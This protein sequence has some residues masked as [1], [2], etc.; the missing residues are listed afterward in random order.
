MQRS[1]SKLPVRLRLAKSELSNITA[2]L[3]QV[4]RLSFRLTHR[5]R[6]RSQTVLETETGQFEVVAH[7]ATWSQSDVPIEDPA[8][9]LY[10]MLLLTTRPEASGLAL[11]LSKEI[12]CISQVLSSTRI[13]LI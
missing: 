3:C 5:P 2:T 9:G 8:W 12:R 10:P 11:H 1:K 4:A 6:W 13:C 7:L